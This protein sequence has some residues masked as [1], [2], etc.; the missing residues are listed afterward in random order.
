MTTIDYT[1]ECDN[2]DH[3]PG[4]I[5]GVPFFNAFNS[6][7]RVPVTPKN[8]PYRPDEPNKL[9]FK[10]LD[11]TFN[12][13]EQLHLWEIR[14]PLGVRIASANDIYFTKIEAIKNTIAIFGRELREGD[15]RVVDDR[16]N[17]LVLEELHRI[18]NEVRETE[19]KAV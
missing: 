9:Y 2:D 5:C 16:D 18:E 3:N 7:T 1:N 11:P 15:H 19:K 17:A 10:K 6:K 12:G 13:D 8:D 14:N 4:C